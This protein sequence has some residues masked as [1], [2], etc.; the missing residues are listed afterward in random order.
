MKIGIIVFGLLT[1]CIVTSCNLST[2]PQSSVVLSSNTPEERPIKTIGLGARIDSLHKTLTESEIAE[3]DYKSTFL[4][5]TNF[6]N[7]VEVLEL[8]S[9]NDKFGLLSALPKNIIT[10]SGWNHIVGYFYTQERYYVI[11]TSWDDNSLY[12]IGYLI[13][14][15]SSFSFNT[16]EVY[17]FDLD[18]VDNSRGFQ[19]SFFDPEENGLTRF[20]VTYTGGVS[21]NQNVQIQEILPGLNEDQAKRYRGQ[22]INVSV[23]KKDGATTEFNDI[24]WSK[25]TKISASSCFPEEILDGIYLISKN[26]YYHNFKGVPDYW[27]F[28]LEACN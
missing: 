10:R 26:W 4:T 11:L 22:G 9:E 13:E 23:L 12:P 17:T 2:K 5:Y 15:D 16:H 24:A 3:F 18:L 21:Y 27:K 6:E 14:I 19:Y 20:I 7:G 8:D 25:S 1:W 28:E